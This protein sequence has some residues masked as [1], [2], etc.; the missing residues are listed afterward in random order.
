MV[1]ELNDVNFP[2]QNS[3]PVNGNICKDESKIP[4]LP[5][6]TESKGEKPAG[7]VPSNSNFQNRLGSSKPPNISSLKEP[8]SQEKVCERG[9]VLAD[10]SQ[11][12]RYEPRDQ[13]VSPVSPVD[14]GFNG[15]FNSDLVKSYGGGN[16]PAPLSPGV[17]PL[18][19]PAPKALDQGQRSKGGFKLRQVYW[20][21]VERFKVRGYE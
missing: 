20:T 11:Q 1:F 17:P 19:P 15:G 21:P 8:Q 10:G 7:I 4:R 12:A 13:W 3:A 2:F 18:P 6:S 16:S 5:P 14:S 9:L